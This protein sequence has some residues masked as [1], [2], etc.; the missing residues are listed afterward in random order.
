MVQSNNRIRLS[1]LV[2]FILAFVP[3]DFSITFF[4]AFYTEQVG[5]INFPF[6]LQVSLLHLSVI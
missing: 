1:N 2:L 6:L 5:T 3:C 4:Y